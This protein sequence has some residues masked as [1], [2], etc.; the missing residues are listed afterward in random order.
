MDE[1]IIF[2]IILVL[3]VFAGVVFGNMYY[4]RTYLPR[5][6]IKALDDSMNKAARVNAQGQRPEAISISEVL[7]RNSPENSIHGIQKL[8]KTPFH[9]GPFADE[10][11]D[12]EWDHVHRFYPQAIE[13]AVSDVVK[14][15]SNMRQIQ[16]SEERMTKLTQS[17][18]KAA[19]DISEGKDPYAEEWAQLGVDDNNNGADASQ[20]PGKG[21]ENRTD[22]PRQLESPMEYA[23]LWMKDKEKHIDDAR[24]YVENFLGKDHKE[25][26]YE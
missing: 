10:L 2:G 13:N 5:Q 24:R 26:H 21:P 15:N 3:F 8:L 11:S 17:Y 20:Q 16:G 23:N 12:E 22:A 25:K 18:K 14:M 6:R 7:D 4:S 1:S 19:E 9:T